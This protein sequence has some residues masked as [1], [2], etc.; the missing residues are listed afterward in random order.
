MRE[1][2]SPL[3]SKTHPQREDRLQAIALG[4]KGA[5]ANVPANPK[6]VENIPQQRD[7]PMPPSETYRVVSSV[8]DGIL[9]MRAGPG[10]SSRLI[11]SIPANATGVEVLRCVPSPDGVGRFKWCNARWQGYEG[12]IS[13]CCVVGEQ[14][15]Q[16]P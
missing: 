4:W 15:N 9:N 11:V 1:L 14:S 6:A 16:K 10:V 12:W 13:S 7:R 5:T 8:S 3:P 2:G